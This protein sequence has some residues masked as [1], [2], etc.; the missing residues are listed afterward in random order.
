MIHLSQLHLRKLRYFLSYPGSWHRE[1]QLKVNKLCYMKLL[2][3]KA[4]EIRRWL[5][6][7]DFLLALP[8]D[9]EDGGSNV[10]RHVGELL[11]EI[12]FFDF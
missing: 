11:F 9:T 2:A 4:L 10:L 7:P 1:L 3:T 5:L 8:Y 6:I 12:Q